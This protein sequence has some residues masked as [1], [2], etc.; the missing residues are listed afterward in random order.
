MPLVKYDTIIISDIHFGSPNCQS[1][2]LFK[3]LGSLRVRQLILN[4]DVFDDINFYRLKHWDWKAFGQIRAVSD[5]C[6]VIWNKGNHDEIN[7]EF[8]KLHQKIKL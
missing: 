3:F 4:G 5:H 6:K 8:Q 1:R 2:E 7:V